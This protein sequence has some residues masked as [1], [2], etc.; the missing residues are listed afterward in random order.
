MRSF[1]YGPTAGGAKPNFRHQKTIRPVFAQR[2]TGTDSAP[3]APG[4]G[5][6]T[7]EKG[8][9]SD[10]ALK[11]QLRLLGPDAAQAS[12]F[13]RVV[14]LFLDGHGGLARAVAEV[15]KARL[16]RF[17]VLLDLDLFQVG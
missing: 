15:I 14:A 13:G 3:Y 10:P 11:N 9:I 4:N 12:G 17:R 7:Q 16:A 6:P 5:R 8:G 2:E 1:H